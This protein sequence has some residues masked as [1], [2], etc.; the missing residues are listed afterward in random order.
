MKAVKGEELILTCDNKVG[1]LEEL[2]TLLKEK[3]INLR[4]ISA[5]VYDSKAAFRLITSDNIKAKEVIKKIG[6]LEMKEVIIVDV[7]DEVGQL[8]LIAKKLKDANIDLTHIYGTT[9]KPHESAIIVFAS[10]DNNKA[11]AIIAA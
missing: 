7:P 2:T 9:S 8:N 3:N 6:S 1:K 5:F 4:G 11:L 10:S